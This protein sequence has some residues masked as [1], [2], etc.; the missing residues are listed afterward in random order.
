MLK[1]DKLS[2]W[3]R[4]TRLTSTDGRDIAQQFLIKGGVFAHCLVDP[5][6]TLQKSRQYIVDIGNGERIVHSEPSNGP[7]GSADTAIPLFRPRVPLAAKQDHLALAA[8]RH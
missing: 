5:S 6:P 2:R 3:D 1:R 4:T 7:L 8:P